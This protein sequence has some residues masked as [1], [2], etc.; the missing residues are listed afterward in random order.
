MDEFGRQ[1][2]DFL[3]RIRLAPGKEVFAALNTELQKKLGVHLTSAQ[4]IDAFE[5]KDI[6]HEMVQIVKNLE[7]VRKRKTADDES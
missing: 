7:D 1:W 2:S 3:L 5:V 4:I 6:P